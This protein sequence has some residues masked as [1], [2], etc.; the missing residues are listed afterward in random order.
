MYPGTHA[1]ERAD[2]AAFVMASTG[3]SVCHAEFEA[4]TNRLAHRLLAQG[5]AVWITAPSSWRTT[6]STWRPAPGEAGL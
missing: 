1:R 3:E 6:T 4:R 2:Q 5:C